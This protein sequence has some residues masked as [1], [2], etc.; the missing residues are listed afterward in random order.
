MSGAVPVERGAVPL[1]KGAVPENEVA[2]LLPMDEIGEP[3]AEEEN[4]EAGVSEVPFDVAAEP[5]LGGEEIEAVGMEV[6]FDEIDGEPEACV[7]GT[8]VVP[9]VAVVAADPEI[10]AVIEA[11]GIEVPFVDTD[12]EPEAGLER[13]DADVTEAVV[14]EDADAEPDLGGVEIEGRE[15]PLVVAALADSGGVPVPEL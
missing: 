5:V 6:A 4:D 1:E 14:F 12:G 7:D 15:V 11:V 9:L 10:G 8:E 2:E 3:E 13:D